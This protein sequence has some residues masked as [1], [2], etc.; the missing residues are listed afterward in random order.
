V[1]AIVT[2]FPAGEQE[3]E[4]CAALLKEG[5]SLGEA[6]AKAKEWVERLFLMDDPEGPPDC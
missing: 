2:S 3:F 4:I 1:R 5:Y 6:T